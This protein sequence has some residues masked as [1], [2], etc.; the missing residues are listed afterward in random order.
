[1][2]IEHS[3]EVDGDRNIDTASVLGRKAKIV[4]II[5]NQ[6]LQVYFSRLEPIP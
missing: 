3:S 2:V 4:N 6:A 1:M 5:C